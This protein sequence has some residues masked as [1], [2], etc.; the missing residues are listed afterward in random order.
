MKHLRI[1]MS[2]LFLYRF[3]A[4]AFGVTA[5]VSLLDS[6]GNSEL[7]PQ[8]AGFLDRLRFAGLRLPIIFDSTFAIIIFLSVLVTY[9][10]FIRRNEIVALLATGVSVFGQLRA[11]AP[12]LFMVGAAGALIVSL[13]SPPAARSLTAWLG[14][15]ALMPQTIDDKALW[16]S[17]PD[18]L[19]RI[20]D[21]SDDTLR[22]LTFFSRSPDGQIIAVSE[23]GRAIYK[24][25]AWQLEG[26]RML[27]AEQAGVAAPK[28]WETRQTPDSLFK[29]Q[30]YPRFLSFGDLLQLYELR[31]SGSRPSSA[32][33]VWI[34]DRLTMPFLAVGLLLLAAP[35]MQRAGR[36][37]T[38]EVA[39]VMALGL[40]FAYLIGDGIFTSM[41]ESGVFNGWVGALGPLIGLF[42]TGLW[43]ALRT[44]KAK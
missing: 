9:L 39:A 38:G 37:E 6:L 29:L 36:R 43:F 40:G 26:T 19:V 32:Y 28:T 30:T 21:M 15:Q 34:I 24:G 10:S 11:L 25:K 14:P 44:E 3:A 35:L 27:H 12:C 2:R 17:E 7:L 42:A 8:D 22:D 16:V 1:Y 20:G 23:A 13:T 33:L 5:L 18:V 4:V 31:G 41:A